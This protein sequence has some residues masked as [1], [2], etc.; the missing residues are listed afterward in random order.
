[1]SGSTG[2]AARSMRNPRSHA[3]A[4]HRQT[5]IEPVRP[6]GESTM[7]TRRLELRAAEGG[8]DSRRLVCT[9]AEGYLRLAETSG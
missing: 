7:E 6:A 4:A 9:L 5:S 8:E 3:V 1:M 2:P